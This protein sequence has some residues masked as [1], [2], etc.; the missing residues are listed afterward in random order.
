M[1]L[2]RLG[3]RYEN[4]MDVNQFI[5]PTETG[6]SVRVSL[7]FITPDDVGE[8]EWSPDEI[9]STRKQISEEI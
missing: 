3:L 4:P 5:K 9:E 1:Y 7:V 8:I 2:F 6:C